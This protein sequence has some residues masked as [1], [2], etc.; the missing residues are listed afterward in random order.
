VAVS[1]LEGRV[2][3]DRQAMMTPETESNTDPT[4]ESRDRDLGFGATVADATMRRLL[5]R[6]GSFNVVRRGLA[7]RQVMSLYYTLLNLTWPRFMLL[8][9]AG[10]LGINTL[11]AFAYVFIGPGALIGPFGQHPFL[12]AFFFS[13]QTISTVGYGTLSPAS[14][15]ANALVTIEIMFGLFGVALVAGLVFARFS[16]PM[17]EIVFSRNAVIAPYQDMTALMFRIA[18]LRRSEII[19]LSA[20]VIFSR[21]EFNASGQR[22]RRF[23]D[24]PLERRK[25]T[26]FP[27]SWTIVHPIDSES[28]L[29]QVDEGSCAEAQA[30]FLV[31]LRGIDETFSQTVHV[32]SSY[33]GSEVVW[34]ARF[35]KIIEL[36]SDSEL[37]AID[38][39]R[40]HDIERLD[41]PPGDPASTT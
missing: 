39:N 7:W 25:V 24:L 13:V 20:Q 38:V 30:E 34:N 32:R 36:P 10:Y 6:D 14:L 21:W 37:L 41:S 33:V 28:P 19:E 9:V 18:N 5:N 8:T 31:L 22:H 29:H 17:A 1:S 40:I 23:Y 4:T 15:G 11:F 27:L 2:S 35:E 26:F 12:Q 3:H 16:R